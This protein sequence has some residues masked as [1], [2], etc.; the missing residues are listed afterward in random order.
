MFYRLHRAVKYFWVAI[1]LTAAVWIYSQREAF[2]PLYA[3]Y[4][5]YENAGL[6]RMEPLPVIEGQ[7]VSVLDGHTF[8]MKS[9]GKFYSVRLTGFEMLTPPLSAAEIELEK[10]RRKVLRDLVVSQHVRV[11][12]TYSNQNSLLGI[13]HAGATNLN[14]LFVANGLSTF[15]RDYVKKIPRDDQ[16]RFFSAARARERYGTNIVAAR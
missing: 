15:K 5:V 7:G 12:V 9:D 13:V 6:Q 16:Y 14:T 3:W 1:I 8:Q 2:E 10:E 4:D 11:D